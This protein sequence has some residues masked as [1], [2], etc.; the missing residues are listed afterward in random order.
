LGSLND[1]N[2]W[3]PN[4]DNQW[5]KLTEEKTRIGWQHIF[6]GRIARTITNLPTIK[7]THQIGSAKTQHTKW[8]RKLLQT[9][10]DTFLRLWRQHNEYI[11]GVTEKSHA[12]RQ[13]AAIS[14]RVIECYQQMDL[15]SAIDRDKIYT[16]SQDELMQE[17]PT[18]IKSW[19]K[20]ATRIIRTS[21]KENRKKTGQKLMMEQYFQWHPPDVTRH[22]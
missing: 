13:R 16:K 1:P 8:P 21:K 10:W 11:H 3:S 18:Y 14:A 2:G 4:Q 5:K 7:P 9:I 22:Q 12:K 15:L 20:L 19:V 17:N 6:F